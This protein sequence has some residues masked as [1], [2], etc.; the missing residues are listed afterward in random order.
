MIDVKDIRGAL[1][2]TTTF[3]DYA[4]GT[5]YSQSVDGLAAGVYFFTVTAN[6]NTGTQKIVVE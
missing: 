4:A 5:V 3:A 1:I 6:G 2:S